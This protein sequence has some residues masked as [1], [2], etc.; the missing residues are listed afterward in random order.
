MD[1]G[2]GQVYVV[3]MGGGGFFCTVGNSSAME[4]AGQVKRV[5]PLAYL[6]RVEFGIH[7]AQDE[8]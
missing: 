4:S 5:L 1:K 7:R 8:E 2:E 3:V 6:G